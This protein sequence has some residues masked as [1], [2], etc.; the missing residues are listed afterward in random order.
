MT[1]IFQKEHLA[2]G[3]I[4]LHMS[5][6]IVSKCS[7]TGFTG[8]L[9]FSLICGLGHRLWKPIK[10]A[11]KKWVWNAFWQ[12][13]WMGLGWY[14]GLLVLCFIPHNS[15]QTLKIERLFMVVIISSRYQPLRAEKKIKVLVSGHTLITITVIVWLWISYTRNGNN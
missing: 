6:Q 1:R 4:E 11:I 8:K 15:V 12:I 7:L 13:Q 10:A 5:A 3:V 2:V 9:Y 14:E